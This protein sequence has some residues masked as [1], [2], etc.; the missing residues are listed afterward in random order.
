[1][2]ITRVIYGRILCEGKLLYTPT[3]ISVNFISSSSLTF[4][5]TAVPHSKNFLPECRM[6]RE[7]V[8]RVWLSAFHVS[9]LPGGLGE[10]HCDPFKFFS[11]QSRHPSVSAT[12]LGLCL[13]GTSG[14]RWSVSHS[15]RSEWDHSLG[16]L[17]I[18]RGS[19]LCSKWYFFLKMLVESTHSSEPLRENLDNSFC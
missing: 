18:C 3:V 11:R 9:L 4:L 15:L 13:W 6:G 2:R 5:I 7:H 10:M 14:W 17:F 12:N 19:L 8:P 1:M 16:C